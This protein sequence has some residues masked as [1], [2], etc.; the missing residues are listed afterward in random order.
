MPP[1]PHNRR[2]RTPIPGDNNIRYHPPTK[3]VLHPSVNIPIPS[4]ADTATGGDTHSIPYRRTATGGGNNH[5]PATHTP[6]TTLFVLL[7]IS[8]HTDIAS[9][10]WYLPIIWMR[11]MGPTRIT[12]YARCGL[13]LTRSSLTYILLP[14]LFPNLRS[15][16]Y[17]TKV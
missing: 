10:M 5:I 12:R 3:H 15:H 17:A 7:P 13:L 8:I 6:T 2:I 4:I 1:V 16:F 9:L 14:F 11:P